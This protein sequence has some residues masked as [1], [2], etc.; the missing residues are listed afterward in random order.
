MWKQIKNPNLDP[1]IYQGGK[2]L[3]SW[4][5]WCLA[6]VQTA[7]GAGW[8]GA[9]AWSSWESHTA[10]KHADYNIPSG[11]YVPI[12]FDGWWN[13]HRYGHVAIWK[14]GKIWSSPISNKPYA[15]T[16]TSIAA[17][18]RAYGMKYVGWSEFVGSTRVIQFDNGE[19]E[20]IRKSQIQAIDDMYREVLGRNADQAGID[21]YMRQI[22]KGW[23]YNAIRNDLLNSQE[24][25]QYLAILEAKRKEAE[26]KKLEAEAQEAKRKAEEKRK[27]EEAERA[28]AEAEKARLGAE[29]LEEER[30]A[31]E[32]F[33]K[34][35]QEIAQAV[36]V[37]KVVEKQEYINT[38][39]DEEFEKLKGELTG[40]NEE[41]QNSEVV[42]E[43]QKS[44]NPKA[45]LAVYLIGD[46]L[47]GLGLIIPSLA[48]VF[49]IG[50]VEQISALASASA[51]AGAFILTMF[52]IYKGKK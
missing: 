10:G 36:E 4:L 24:R 6:Y 13:G 28:K 7:F 25:R 37:E 49:Q 9:S 3:T 33:E 22:L 12:W 46:S 17:V 27:L 39:T 51:T 2:I 30:L 43:I 23:D 15:D 26:A 48:V 32:A 41:I 34:E 45:K 44:I 42:K 18:E 38:L 29:R 1:V 50:T 14:D 35:Q 52:G 21:H 16:F 8:S 19:A 5:G 20:R 47:I 31:K 11:V 40:M